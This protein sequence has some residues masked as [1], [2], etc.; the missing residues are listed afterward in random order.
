VT[1]LSC[2]ELTRQPWFSGRTLDL[3]AGELVVL[4]GPTGSGKTLFL[5]GLADLDPTDAGEVFLGA[6]ERGTMAAS[7]WRRRVMYVHQSGVTL[8]G[9][10]REHVERLT[11]VED[12]P[13]PQGLSGE[14]DAQRLSGGERQVLALH[15]ALLCQPDVLLLDESTSAMD[16]DTAALWEARLRAWVD[17]GHAALWVA[18]DRDLAA[19]V[20]ART[21]RFS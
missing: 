6:E 2:R 11:Q 16:P 8:P 5:R 15:C 21:V 14:A 7:R 9:T 13:L 17:E 1:L 20:G 12:A 18:H 10:V 3:D 19:R 4:S